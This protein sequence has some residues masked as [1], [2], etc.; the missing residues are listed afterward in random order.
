MHTRIKYKDIHDS[1]AE[2]LQ[3]HA[4]E[5]PPCDHMHTRIKDKDIDDFIAES[6]Q[7]HAQEATVTGTRKRPLSLVS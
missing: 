5:R 3:I 1:I 2:S 6:L 4:Y 7:I